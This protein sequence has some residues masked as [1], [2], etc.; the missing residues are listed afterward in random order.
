MTTETDNQP[1]E[2]SFAEFEAEV[3]GG[4][5]AEPKAE[6]ENDDEP[7]PETND[8]LELTEDDELVEDEDEDKGDKKP[9]HKSAKQ[10]IDEITAARRQ[11]ERE[12]DELRA[13][14]ARM[15][16]DPAPQAQEPEIVAPNP[17]DFEFG[18][19]DPKYIE[20]LTDYKVDVKLAERDKAAKQTEAQTAQRETLSNL[21]NSWIEQS[22]AAAEKY[23]DF[24]EKI[25]DY[26]ATAPCPPLM[27]IAIQASPVAADVAYHLANNS[28]ENELIAV[29]VETNPM[30]A[31][32]RI[33]AIEGQFMTERPKHPGANAHPLEKALHAGRL[34]AFL[35]KGKADPKP[36][37]KIATDAPEPARHRVRGG[38]GKFEVDDATDD[39][40]AFEAKVM[41]GRR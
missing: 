28:D 21:D 19:A 40:K 41:R 27:A 17:D 23:E 33:G 16:G 31:A 4:A 39:F 2:Q 5:K 13:E 8:E 15:R 1:Q 12:R 6:P 34:K 18:E 3:M 37:A 9:R 25:A 36:T 11:A 10:R 22:E 24:D 32:E 35:A 7:N 29:E 26:Q 14:I 38:A 30:S 20:A